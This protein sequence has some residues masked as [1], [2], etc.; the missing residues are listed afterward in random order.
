M[1]REAEVVLYSL[2]VIFVHLLYA[3]LSVYRKT[4]ELNMLSES[5]AG[6]I[7]SARNSERLTTLAANN[8][9]DMSP[10]L[11]C[12]YGEPLKL[13]VSCMYYHFFCSGYFLYSLGFIM[14]VFPST[15]R[16]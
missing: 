2:N 5:S 8:D 7:V 4:T 11:R 12:M 10:K 15:V 1:R 9:W 14:F 16:V 13:S 6:F 3:M